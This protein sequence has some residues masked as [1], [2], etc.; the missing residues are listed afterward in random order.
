MKTKLI[1]LLCSS[2]L[3]ACCM[4]FAGCSSS[5]SAQ[6]ETSSG[7]SADA[8]SEETGE[9]GAQATA[10]SGSETANART[11]KFLGDWQAAG[12]EANGITMTGDIQTMGQGWDLTLSV[13][14]GGAGTFSYGGDDFPV[15]WHV[16]DDTL[17]IESEMPSA[18]EQMLL[19][20]RDTSYD[21]QDY[22]AAGFTYADGSLM[23]PL[24]EYEQII[25]TKDGTI[26]DMPAIQADELEPLA[27][28]ENV[29]GAWQLSA[30]VTDGT[31]FY[32]PEATLLQFIFGMEEEDG[33]SASLSFNEDGMATFLGGELMWEA[34]D[35][36]LVLTDSQMQLPV[37]SAGDAIAIDVSELSGSDMMMVYEREVAS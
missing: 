7:E 36:K 32:G 21:E 26:A 2:L 4:A 35:G 18:G 22:I 16:V 30:V 19:G 27:S 6:D 14:E 25:L 13:D 29:M 1:T 10:D 5:Q 31:T 12:Y 17:S 15:N 23:L 3:A 37:S 34:E 24:S 8:T 11:D 33:A 28:A 20:F 9:A